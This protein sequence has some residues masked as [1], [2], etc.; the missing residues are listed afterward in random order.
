MEVSVQGGPGCGEPVKAPMTPGDLEMV[1]I[2]VKEPVEPDS[3][4]KNQ[5]GRISV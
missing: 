3:F 1:E 5:E 2:R 4:F